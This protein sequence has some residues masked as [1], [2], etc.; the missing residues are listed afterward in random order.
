ME[1]QSDECL[2]TPTEVAKYLHVSK[3]FVYKLIQGSAMPY[4]KVGRI[5]RFRKSEV[6]QWMADR[7][8]AH[9]K[10]ADEQLSRIIG[11]MGS[12]TV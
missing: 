3:S 12:Q 11:S 6:D 10:K 8:A 1:Q 5:L 4:L 9:S 2:M 7:T